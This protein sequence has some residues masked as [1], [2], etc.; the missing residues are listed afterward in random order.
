MEQR[1]EVGLIV[2]DQAAGEREARCRTDAKS[3]ELAFDELGAD[4][5]AA[6]IGSKTVAEGIGAFRLD[7]L[8]LRLAAVLVGRQATDRGGDREVGGRDLIDVGG[9]G[10]GCVLEDHACLVVGGVLRRNTVQIGVDDV[11]S[12]H[13]RG[14]KALRG[15]GV[16]CHFVSELIARS[17][18]RQVLRVGVRVVHRQQGRLVDGSLVV[19][20]EALELV[21]RRQGQLVGHPPFVFHE[22]LDVG[23]IGGQQQ[24]ERRLIGG[25]R[26]DRGVNRTGRVVD[27]LLHALVADAL[28]PDA[29]LQR[30][31]D[32]GRVDVARHI[33][34]VA[35]GAVVVELDVTG[36]VAGGK[37]INVSVLGC[38]ARIFDRGHGSCAGRGPI[39]LKCLVVAVVLVV[40]IP[41][42]IGIGGVVE[43][44][45]TEIPVGADIFHIRGLERIVVADEL[46]AQRV[47]VYL[48]VALAVGHVLRPCDRVDVVVVFRAAGGERGDLHIAKL[49][50]D[51]QKCLVGLGSAILN[52]A[53]RRDRRNCCESAGLVLGAVARL[54]AGAVGERVEA[55]EVAGQ[56]R[57]RLVFERQ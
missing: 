7:A 36:H 20:I 43:L 32:E 50:F 18:E 4:E 8:I 13:C 54:N 17:E 44:E 51:L 26:V 5:C 27:I 30:A 57:T 16:K 47:A 45:A 28:H 41:V 11:V 14:K 21:A 15:L 53:I 35:I 56:A 9:E 22:R 24:L 6:G 25:G 10:P 33:E 40:R 19:A 46:L 37:T 42:G 55:A 12:R 39:V 34:D 52:C 3:V 23:D 29:S 48:A 31:I 38:L 2:I 49:L 1:S